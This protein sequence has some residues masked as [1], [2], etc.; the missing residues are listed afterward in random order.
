MFA[1]AA[2]DNLCIVRRGCVV[3]HG[4]FVARAP[5]IWIQRWSRV[6]HSI[7]HLFAVMVVASNI[8]PCDGLFLDVA[9][10][11]TRSPELVLVLIC[12]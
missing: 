9:E 5:Q 1:I 10:C 7:R 8:F 6:A 3:K 12:V 4:F 11:A 2:S